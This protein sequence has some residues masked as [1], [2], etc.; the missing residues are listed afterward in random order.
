M[1]LQSHVI[2]VSVYNLQKCSFL[3]QTYLKSVKKADVDV[4]RSGFRLYLQHMLD[5]YNLRKFLS[6]LPAVNSG[7]ITPP[8]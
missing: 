6:S 3:T 8:T 5:V 7:I 4:R 1:V 2:H